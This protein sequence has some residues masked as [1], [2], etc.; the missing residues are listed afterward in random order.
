M[1][2]AE[3]FVFDNYYSEHYQTIK[4]LANLERVKSFIAVTTKEGSRGI[5][6]KNANRAHVVIAFE[7]KSVSECMQAL[8]RG[9]RSLDLI[10]EGT[11]I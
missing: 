11:L 10:A 9:S 8:G 1:P 2:L 7:P 6:F 5:D 3:F 4:K